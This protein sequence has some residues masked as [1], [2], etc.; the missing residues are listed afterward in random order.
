MA[1]R[2]RSR[3]DIPQRHRE[4]EVPVTPRAD[5]AREAAVTERA[6]A[7]PTRPASYYPKSPGAMSVKREKCPWK[8]TVM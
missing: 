8:A 3:D 1:Y 5:D 7:G 4:T 6:D 2:A